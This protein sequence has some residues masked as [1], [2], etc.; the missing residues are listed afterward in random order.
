[1]HSKF[2]AKIQEILHTH[3][4][5]DWIEDVHISGIGE[6]TKTVPE[7][8]LV[9]CTWNRPDVLGPTLKSISQS[10][11]NDVLL[12]LVDD[13]SEDME[14]KAQI[15]GFNPDCPCIKI[16]KRRHG[17]IHNSLLIGW[18][19]LTDLGCKKLTNLDSDVLVKPDWVS[20][21]L[22]LHASLDY[23][24][25]RLILS[26][27]NR[28][29]SPCIVSSFER[30]IVKRR[31]GGIN[32]F[33]DPSVFPIVKSCLTDMYWDLYLQDHF[34]SQKT[35]GFKLVAARPSV[36]QHTGTKGVN[37]STRGFDYAADFDPPVQKAERYVISRR[38]TGLG[39]CLGSLYIAWLYARKTGRKL[40]VDWRFMP[41]PVPSGENPFAILFENKHEIAGVP[42]LTDVENI[43]REETRSIYP[44][45]R[46]IHP[47]EIS[48]QAA[49][50]SWPAERMEI[51]NL[52]LSGQDR[53]EDVIVMDHCLVWSSMMATSLSRSFFS[54]LI[55]SSAV[56]ERVDKFFNQSKLSRPLLG[57]HIRH[58]NGGD[59]MNHK[60]AWENYSI[61]DC[62]S[63]ISK[64]VGQNPEVKSVFLA[65]DSISVQDAICNEMEHVYH[66]QK[67]FRE[68]GEGELH[69]A[70]V[71]TD[72]LLDAM[73]DLLILADCEAIL[74]FPEGS[75]FSLIAREFQK[76]S[77]TDAK[78][79]AGILASWNMPNSALSVQQRHISVS[80]LICFKAAGKGRLENLFYVLRQL[81]L[82]EDCEVVLVEQ[83]VE[84]K[85]DSP[86]I[87]NYCNYHFIY[88]SGDFNKSWGIN[89]AAKKSKGDVLIVID[90]DMFID[91]GVLLQGVDQVRSGV[92]AI[93]PYEYLVDLTQEETQA[94]LQ[95]DQQLNISRTHEQLN[96]SQLRQIPPF[97]GGIFIIDRHFYFSVG[98]MDERFSG[99]GA[100]D[101]AMTLRVKANSREV[102]I[103]ENQMAYHL[104]H[105][106]D[107]QQM[108]LSNIA[109]NKNLCLLNTY[110]EFSSKLIPFFSKDAWTLGKKNK[111]LKQEGVKNGSDI[112][113]ISCLCVTRKRVDKLKRAI[114]CFQEQTYANKEL[115]I[116]CDDDDQETIQFLESLDQEDIS[117]E[118]CERNRFNTL[119]AIRNYSIQICNG[120]FF[121]QWDDDDWY[122]PNR[123][124]TQYG[125]I[126]KSGKPATI[127]SQ[128]TI[129]SE[130]DDKAYLSNIR[131]WEGSI[132]CRKDIF[133]DSNIY[134]DVKRGEEESLV[135]TLM[136]D[137]QVEI[138]SAPDMYVYC[139][140]GNNTWDDKHFTQILQASTLYSDEE[141]VRIKNLIE[142]FGADATLAES[143]TYSD[144]HSN[145][146]VDTKTQSVKGK[147]I[148]QTWRSKDVPEKL[149][150]LVASWQSMH[151]DWEHCLWTDD[152]NRRLIS[153]HYDWFLPLY[154]RLPVPIQRVDAARYFI[155]YTLGG[156]YV[157]L[158]FQC[159]KNIEPLIKGSDLLLGEEHPDHSH[160][161]G[162]QRI[163]GNAFIW[164]AQPGHPFLKHLI[165]EMVLA[166]ERFQ[167]INDPSTNNDVLNTTGPFLLTDVLD[168][169]PNQGRIK[170]VPYEQLYPVS[171][172]QSEEFEENPE[173]F[174]HFKQETDAYAAHYH[175]GSWWK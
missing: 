96:R 108:Q 87:P 97:C 68:A 100:E 30:Y 59:I 53:P 88:N 127:L 156:L 49:N 167:N 154:D 164:A 137:D 71:N 11:L 170:V 38:W 163:V 169:Y 115:V 33:F 47:T 65:T 13:K 139:Y 9:V 165:E 173:L 18:T 1:M 21:L 6:V 95:G 107:P 130:V 141:A 17:H 110:I 105:E 166:V 126:E 7:V 69:F 172:Q 175:M 129:Y 131:F 19:L 70:Q 120:E 147:F 174:E 27:F 128:W 161:H 26:G 5:S 171:Y 56:R 86:L 20:V 117:Y 58:G 34:E 12:V 22:D 2:K 112:P 45:N 151:A 92:D 135:R 67:Y 60:K 40:V 66:Y 104:W 24:K 133:S 140:S 101:D 84:T 113:L 81:D 77:D 149:R 148:H 16:T 48:E 103:L 4:L 136:L 124:T 10:S 121:C 116:I 39:D 79:N 74:G 123:L 52:V 55:P 62:A 15:E 50:G 42:L 31:M 63:D 153:E 118:I 157:D 57:V 99:W 64:V 25:D 46:E 8:G 51:M 41:Y 90:A 145:Q 162:K 14:T 76:S 89:Y 94:L 125:F 122:H 132:L 73:A 119:G 155:L 146:K 83:D 28:H 98:G 43:A 82:G 106:S 37:S 35:Q 91:A 80:C 75:Y 160:F 144:T 93:N 72:V 143:S 23:P 78:L 61:A 152:D 102:R 29:N 32:Y 159:F 36:V 109:Y 114:Q 134:L 150:P 138:G 85:I 3:S 142:D 158:D 44:H 54:S 168:R 111:Y